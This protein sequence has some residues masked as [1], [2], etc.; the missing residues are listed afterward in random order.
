MSVATIHPDLRAACRARLLTVSGLP[1]MSWEGIGIGYGFDGPYI[2]ESF[3]P[4]YSQKRAVGP[5][6]TVLH[7]CTFNLTL[8]YPAGKGTV[9]IEAMAGAILAAF[10]PGTSLVYGTAKG[11]V[12]Q[13]ERRGL[14]QSPDYLD[15]PVI[16][17][18]SAYTAG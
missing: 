17:T 15:C 12:E 14:G 7:R 2:N 4:I 3:R 18:L 6:G 13:A 10:A 5:T 8:F 9:D 16:I 1:D 11:L